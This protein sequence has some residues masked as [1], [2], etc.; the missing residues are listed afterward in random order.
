M[1]QS[2]V[3]VAHQE[4]FEELLLAEVFRQKHDEVF[5]GEA[6]ECNALQA[7]DLRRDWIG[8]DDEPGGFLKLGEVVD[9]DH[10]GVA[11]V[12]AAQA[13]A[14]LSLAAFLKSLTLLW[15]VELVHA[16]NS[17]ADLSNGHFLESLAYLFHLLV[18]VESDPCLGKD[19]IQ[20]VELGHQLDQVVDP[21]LA[22]LL[23]L[24]M[25]EVW[26]VEEG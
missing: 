23:D 21:D 24:S 3:A 6:F 14:E 2:D 9:C 7:E 16:H 22:Q 12:R 1:V 15:F 20:V 19:S 8:D 4:D 17:P 26:H 11:A 13:N 18:V 5:L 10:L 25:V